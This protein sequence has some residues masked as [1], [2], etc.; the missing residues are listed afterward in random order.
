[1]RGYFALGVEG[2]SKPRNVGAVL[3]TAH[4]FGASFT[5]AIAP[6][7]DLDLVSTTD[8]SAA[9]S[10]VP[11][12][13]V[14]SVER[15]LLPAGCRLVA[16]ELH[17][18]AVALPSFRH[19]LQAA[20]VLGPEQGGLSD[21]LLARADFVVRIPTRFSINLS[22]AGGLVL[23]DRLISRGRFADRPVSPGGPAAPAG[24]AGEA[25]RMAAGGPPR[26]LRRRLDPGV[27]EE[28]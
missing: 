20:Y 10:S 11:F 17:D 7:A 18:R 4:A 9:A 21:A 24:E 19:P 23:Y 28:V 27:A 5:F 25:G 13:Q 6:V 8:T 26:Y 14:P 12:Y 2:I 1:M 22:L 3:R 16:V 15:L